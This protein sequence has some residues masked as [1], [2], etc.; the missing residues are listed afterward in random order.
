MHDT[1]KFTIF[2]IFFLK[3]E[4]RKKIKKKKYIF[5]VLKFNGFTELYCIL[6]F[7]ITYKYIT[8]K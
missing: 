7:F 6:C 5:K 2:N 4:K 1:I 8:Y 3:Y